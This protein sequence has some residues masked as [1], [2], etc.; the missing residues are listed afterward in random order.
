[1]KSLLVTLVLSSV[2]MPAFAMQP[3]IS[4]KTMTAVSSSTGD[5]ERRSGRCPHRPE[6]PLI[7]T[8]SV[9]REGSVC[10]GV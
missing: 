10:G 9:S 4:A 5:I 2:A 6:E 7:D 1:M 3:M 8:K